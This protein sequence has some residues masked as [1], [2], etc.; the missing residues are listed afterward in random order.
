ME[1]AC[2]GKTVTVTGFDPTIASKSLRIINAAIAYDSPESGETIVLIV[3]QAIHNPNV[4]HNLLCPLQL[5]TN[6]VTVN[7]TPKFVADHPTDQDHVILVPN[8]GDDELRIPLQIRGTTSTFPTRRPTAAEFAECRHVEL[9]YD[10]PEWDPSTKSYEEQ[11]SAMTDSAG[12]L[13]ETG[14]RITSRFIESAVSN[15]SS[16]TSARTIADMSSQSTAVLLDVDPRLCAGEFSQQLQENVIVRDV[17]AASSRRKDRVDASILARNWG[18]GLE[19]AAKT[20]QVTTQRGARTTLHPSLTRRAK[21]NDRH[22]R[23]RR[24][25]RNL[26]GDL[27]ESKVKSLKGNKYAQIFAADNGWCRAFGLKQKSA[28]P[29]ALSILFARD[30]VPP[31]MIVDGGRELIS[32]KYRKLC[33]DAGSEHRQTL[34]R[35][36]WQ[37]TAEGSIRE[38][39][40]ETGRAMIATGTP[41]RLWDDC[42]EYRAYVRSNTALNIFDLDGQ[43]PETVMT[44]QQAD[45]SPWC[46]FQWYQWVKYY[47]ERASFPED[48]QVLGKYLG[49]SPGVGTRMT[50]KI[51]TKD[52]SYFHTLTFRP[53]NP[54][55]VEKE[56][57]QRLAFLAHVEQRLGAKSE[58]GDFEDGL[59]L[60]HYEM[61]HYED[62]NDGGIDQ[63][64]DREEQQFEHFDRYLNAEV[65]LNHR[66]SMTTGR[67]SSRKREHDGSLVG[68]GN[69]NP[70]LDTRSYMVSFEDGSEAEYSANVLAENMFAQCDSDGNQFLLMEAV[71]DHRKTKDAV[72][73]GNDTFKWRGREHLKRTTKGWEFCI[74][75]RDGTTSWERLAVL[76]ESNP[77]EVAEYSVAA[78]IDK[79]PAFKW[80]VPYTLKKRKR[81]IAAVN[82]RVLKRDH[83]FGIRIPRTVEEALR[84]DKENG[85]TLW[86][87]SMVKEMGNVRVAFNILPEDQ[88]PP[89]AHTKIRTHIIFDV[90][91]ETLRRKARLVAGGHVTESPHP[92]LTYASVVSR[93]SV[94]IALTLAALNDLE[95]KA[96]DIQNAYLTAPLLT[97]KIWTVCGPEF[98]EDQGKNAVVVRALYGLKSAGHDYGVHIAQCMV[99]LG[100]TPCEADR[101]VWMK[102]MV[103]PDDGHVYFAYALL[104]VDDI[105]MIHHDG[106]RAIEQIDK[107]FKM[108]P[109][110]NP[111]GKYE[112]D[113]YLGAKLR[114]V[115]I[116][117]NNVWAY[118]LSPYQYVREN[119]RLVEK[120]LMEHYGQKLKTSKR[121]GTAPF[122]NG[123]RAET[124]LSE[125]LGTEEAAYY[126]SQIGILR[127]MVELGRIG[128]ITEVSMLASHIALPR[129]GHLDAVFA[130]YA[131]LKTHSNSTMV[132]DPTYPTVIEGDFKHCD[133]KEYYPGAEEQISPN[134]PT[135]R[136]K[137]IDLRMY[138]D[139]DHAGDQLNRRSRTGYIIYVQKAPVIWHSKKQTRVE[140]SVF[141]AEFCA[142]TQGMERLRG[143]RYKLRMMGVPISGPSFVYGDNMSVIH[144]TQRPESRLN[145]KSN[146]ICYHACR[147]AVAGG[148][149]RTGHV[150]SEMNPADICTKIIPGGIKR[151]SLTKMVLY[152]IY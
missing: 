35:S 91:M 121:Q 64:P 32:A 7:E 145:K 113:V 48:K 18:L 125:E 135:A 52:G 103:R 66:D 146:S 138:V 136:G 36:Q 84:I 16:R 105:L 110:T 128:I 38:L 86:E 99:H 119:I 1:T 14:D 76:K 93:E 6:G 40:K 67:V 120:Y 26:Y 24:L 102:P 50:A 33:H 104:Y 124:D 130:V 69:D 108:K 82:K 94:R 74:E 49:P 75:W 3:N 57:E 8:P 144:N 19:A 85:N 133:W 112:P 78:G 21:T 149:A 134:A 140:T 31:T 51:L 139:S 80:W 116:P 107:Y 4:Q 17:S 34:P 55:E 126:H 62:D 142:M 58:P 100:Y 137:E 42:L 81:I 79:M 129:R 56:V 90:K 39:K 101:D 27:L 73:L 147:E 11:E 61:S 25:S 41:K 12:R 20:V 22:I 92:S 23:Y 83:K 95:V 60:D 118:S 77:V 43:V 114:K 45:I 2:Y 106:V 87:D 152:D 117:G 63:M 53:L 96:S 47:D 15:E 127:W 131:F 150:R 143:L 98:G 97:E 123:Y 148:E 30:G 9:T 59:G 37:N 141:G 132:F 109:D 151:K 28:A 122:P 88:P 65:L 13:L 46:D 5:R 68:Q 72:E 10:D 54:E 115:Q 89:I 29:D 70:I 71:T 44:G 111:N